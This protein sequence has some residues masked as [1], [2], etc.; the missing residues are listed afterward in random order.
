MP[1]GQPKNNLGTD[2]ELTNSDP[3]ECE[4]KIEEELS[5]RKKDPIE[6]VPATENSS[7]SPKPVN[8]LVAAITSEQI[9]HQKELS[10][11]FLASYEND[12]DG[13]FDFF[14]KCLAAE[15][16]EKP[17]V[18]AK[19]QPILR[20]VNLTDESSQKKSKFIAL[21]VSEHLDF[22]ENP[23]QGLRKYSANV[24]HQVDGHEPSQQEIE[25]AKAAFKKRYPEPITEAEWN[26]CA[27][28]TPM[29]D[30]IRTSVRESENSAHESEANR[31]TEIIFTQEQLDAAIERSEMNA[32]SFREDSEGDFDS[33]KKWLAAQRG[34]KPA[35]DAKNQP[36]LRIVNF[37]D[38]SSQK[39]SKFIALTDS[40]HL[41]FLESPRQGLRKYSANVVHQVDG[42][43][44][45][46][47][48]IE[49]AKTAFKNRFPEIA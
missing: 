13:E 40:E 37:T 5:N 1:G 15:R 4:Q 44:P 22:L 17:V 6:G 42:H 48:E 33:F 38:E 18:D 49:D 20:I 12:T 34:E 29:G 19:N 41:D 32:R 30:R 26:V 35:V 3:L 2:P 46:Q 24:I 14:K 43:E 8:P 23:E 47:Q 9:V 36:K 31:P 27:D 39:K 21:T 16:E 7:D 45:S 25:V 10:D 28:P 11:K